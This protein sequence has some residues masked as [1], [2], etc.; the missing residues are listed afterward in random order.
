MRS[1]KI[2]RGLPVVLIL[3]IF[4]SALLMTATR[5]VAQ[6]ETVLHSFKD[7]GKGGS[8][9]YANLTIDSAGNLYGTTFGGGANNQGTVFELFPAIG[10]GWTGK[11]LHSFGNGEDGFLPI[12]GLTFDGSGNLYGTTVDGGAYAGIGK[13]GGTVFKLSPN[14][15]GSWTE[16]VLH[17][18]GNGTDG[19]FVQGAVALDASGNIYG[20]TSYGG[21]Y[22]GDYAGGTVFELK[23]ETEGGY[24]EHVLHNFGS[25]DDGQYPVG[26]VILDAAGNL[27][28]TTDLGGGGSGNGIVFELARAAGSWN[29][30][31]LY[32]FNS[33]LGANGASPE[34]S[35]V[36]DS[37]GNLYGTTFN[38]GASNTGTVFELSPATGGSWTESVLH[39]FADNHTDGGGSFAT[40]VFDVSGNLYGTTAN[41]GAYLDGTAF[42]LS[43][44][45]GGVWTETMLHSFG[46]GGDGIQ[47][48]AGLVMDAS[49]NLYGTTNDGGIGGGGG[50]VFE[51]AP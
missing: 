34:A 47:P 46:H 20:T 49:G 33:S 13:N 19:Q 41:G 15:G 12:A 22:G 1:Q 44:S 23:P 40:L 30:T 7:M 45:T 9:P 25:G 24:S 6:T 37:V 3:A 36:F 11:V 31:I 14:T 29:E 16:K 17:S 42:E 4:S 35:L 38:G 50:T 39:S 2:S 5:A 43:P 8:F 51:V 10:G 28:G 21:I 27:Y 48:H 18:F 32:N 26:G